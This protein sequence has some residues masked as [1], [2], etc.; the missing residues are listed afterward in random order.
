MICE[1][2][3][4]KGWVMRDSLPVFGVMPGDPDKPQQPV[5]IWQYCPDC[6]GCGRAH[7]CEG[8][9]PGNVEKKP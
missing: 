5:S 6:D 3:H 4:G 1:T 2:C 9:R 7:C 8:E